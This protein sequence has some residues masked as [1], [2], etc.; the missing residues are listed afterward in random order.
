VSKDIVVAAKRLA[1]EIE[2]PE[3]QARATELER[4]VWRAFGLPR[5]EARGERDL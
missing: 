5:E 2:T 3:A 4:L 1:D